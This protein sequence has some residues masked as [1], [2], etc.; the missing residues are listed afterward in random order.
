MIIFNVHSIKG[1]TLCFI[2]WYSIKFYSGMFFKCINILNSIFIGYHWLSPFFKKGGDPGEPCLGSDGI[3]S[4]GVCYGCRP[5]AR[6]GKLPS[7][8]CQILVLSKILYEL[9]ELFVTEMKFLDR[10]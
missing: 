7:L 4:V 5:G 10:N 8:I 3:V 9:L 6:T 2:Q 1:L